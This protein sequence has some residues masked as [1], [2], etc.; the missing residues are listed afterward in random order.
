MNVRHRLR[1]RLGRSQRPSVSPL[2]WLALT[3]GAGCLMSFPF[4]GWSGALSAGIALVFL[5]VMA[6]ALSSNAVCGD[7]S[8]VVSA[9]RLTA[10][11]SLGISVTA[12][13]PGVSVIPPCRALMP[14][15]SNMHR[16]RFP[17][18]GIGGRESI[19]LEVESRSRCVLDIGPVL[20]RSGDPLGL[21]HGERR[22]TDACRVF[23]HPRTVRF[24][25]PDV[26][27]AHDLDGEPSGRI[28][29]DDFDFQ[30]LREYRPGDD[31]RGVHWLSTSRT[32]KLM[33][34]QHDASCRVDTDL[35][36]DAD[37]SG[38]ADDAEFE[39]AVSIFAS[40]GAQC[41][42]SRRP[43]TAQASGECVRPRHADEFLDFC[44]TIAAVS[45]PA[46]GAG[47]GAGRFDAPWHR[48]FALRTG[49]SVLQC[50]VIGSRHDP[51][52]YAH[53][54][55]FRSGT[56][57]LVVQTQP[58]PSDHETYGRHDGARSRVMSMYGTVVARIGALD[59]LPVIMEVLS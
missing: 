41:L 40:I 27:A 4:T 17:R 9:L 59:E 47:F 7:V 15:G 33:V 29:D 18:L 57:R 46:P 3:F 31:L 19:R 35:L 51:A 10:G 49:P 44:S 1:Q 25:M 58:E 12:K 26:G 43:L 2:G 32:G 54:P 55:T 37:G 21:M 42:L 56:D 36:I 6:F 8:I 34:R 5:S 39:L 52:T 22:G 45:E 50:T 24:R 38:Y 28:V 13:N 16:I 23:V 30:G 48:S 53:V 11:E 20:I 14:V